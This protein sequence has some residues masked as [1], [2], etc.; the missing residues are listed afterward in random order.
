MLA[1]ASLL[2]HDQH[3]VTGGHPECPER[4]QA[5]MAGLSAAV[6]SEMIS[7]LTVTPAP[8]E[9]L[10]RVHDAQYLAVVEAACR[11]GIRALDPDTPISRGS[12]DTA[13]LAA[14]AGLDVVTAID[15]GTA[16]RGFVVSRP[17]GHHATPNRAMGFCLL[18][19]VAVTAAA[20]RER[21][22]RV[23]VVDW[24]VHHGN[25][26]QDIFWNDPEVMFVSIHEAPPAYPGTGAVHETGGS[27]APGTTINVP[28]PAGATGDAFRHAVDEVIAPAAAAFG[29][30]WLLISAG[31]DAHR[32]DPLADLLL[33]SSDYADLTRSLLGLV[34]DARGVIAFLEGGYDLDALAHSL[35]ATAAA[36]VGIDIHPEPRSTGG[37][38]H[39]AVAAARRAHLD[40]I[41]A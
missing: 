17:P 10:R 36:L 22:E 11:R 6:P 7:T 12:W 28:L 26:T 40:A 31:Y 21:G 16:T 39:D 41:G 30:T 35:G 9:A 14:G 38:G 3:A 33:T 20:L 4:L 37:P 25:G 34:P 32:D 15:A 18:N 13:L 2:G 29:P 19:N 24:D 5:A 27:E 23:L 8:H 1:V